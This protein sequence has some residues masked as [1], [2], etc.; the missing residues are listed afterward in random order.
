MRKAKSEID[1]LKKERDE[2]REKYRL[3]LERHVSLQEEN[4]EY[5]RRV[6]KCPL[7]RPLMLGER[8]KSTP[9]GKREVRKDIFLV[10]SDVAIQEVQ[11]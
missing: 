2:W 3:L 9:G 11:P 8:R 4:L 5:I 1:S 10:K 6:R 7:C